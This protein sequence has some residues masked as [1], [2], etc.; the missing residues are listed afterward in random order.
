MP[1][2][3]LKPGGPSEIPLNVKTFRND[4]V[5]F[6][7]EGDHRRLRP[8]AGTREGEVASSQSSWDPFVLKAERR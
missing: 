1:E 4:S 5:F 6:S 8:R 3:T 2:R 7:I